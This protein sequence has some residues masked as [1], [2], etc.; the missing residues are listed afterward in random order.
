MMRA[1]LYWTYFCKVFTVVLLI[2]LLFLASAIAP[3]LF[4]YTPF[5]VTDS[6]NPV[7][8]A[9]TLAFCR[10]IPAAQLQPGDLIAVE[11]ADRGK[12]CTVIS[13]HPAQ[14]LVRTAEE[15]VPLECIRGKVAGFRARWLGTVLRIL[16]RPV[17][18][19]VLCVLLGLSA[20]G[21]FWLPKRIYIPR[22]GQ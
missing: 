10:Y 14:R 8:T 20:W 17:S 4:G 22:F 7:C 5:C 3:A 15:S 16:H 19:I 2:P 13:V 6:D 12:V 9:E 21:G 1:A 11:S 18:W